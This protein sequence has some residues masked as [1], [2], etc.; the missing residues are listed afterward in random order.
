MTVSG[1]IYHKLIKENLLLKKEIERLQA[2]LSEKIN[3]KNENG[4]NYFNQKFYSILEHV[5]DV[6][7][8][9]SIK[10]KGYKYISPQVFQLLGYT[11]EEFIKSPSIVRRLIHPDSFRY[12]SEHWKKLHMG[13]VSDFYELKAIRKNKEIIWVQQRNLLI[14]DE[15]GTPSA[16]E[17]LV[18]DITEKKMAEGAL[19]KAKEKAEESDRLKSAFLA[20]TSHEILTPMNAIIGFAALLK[21][22]K[23]SEERKNSFIDIINSKSKQ[24]LQ[25]ISDII[26]I[27]KIEAGHIKIINKNFSLNVL[28][29]QL[30]LF[31]DT[32]KE[33]EKKLL[34][35]SVKNCL[36]DKESWI[37]SDKVRIEQI[38]TNFLSNAYK[39]TEKGRIEL[40]YTIEHNQSIVFYVRDTGI[41]INEHELKIIF[42]RFRQVS[43]SFSRIYGGVGLGLSIS[44]GI[45]EKLGGEIW[46][47][48]E[49][50]KG[51]TFYLRI[52]YKKGEEIK[53]TKRPKSEAYNWESKTILVA[54][55][56]D[57][58]YTLIE[59]LLKP[60][61]VNLLR[62][63]TG[64]EAIDMCLNKDVN[65]VLMDVKL[66]ELDG[67]EAS[68]RIKKYRDTLP[69]I[70]QT[71]YAMTSDEDSCL[72]AGC[73]AYISKPI[74]S[75]PL[76]KLIDQFI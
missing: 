26:D 1:R 58:N 35:I 44:K 47:E 36:S 14:T 63:I 28:T 34:R 46:V 72:K 2:T 49:I 59:T 3:C 19:V 16:I 52:P 61:K 54:E 41:G 33:R 69:I 68:R 37:Y 9:Y 62:A 64:L 42:D 17:G 4:N 22:K 6:V 65:L 57:V 7:Y 8:H 10:D 32:L 50:N 11:P 27:S 45:A 23:L 25:I 67:L 74:I 43:G 20:N 48:S 30:V 75:E 39:F 51:S 55:D 40:G 29:G 71:A 31:L 13:M 24:L 76:L 56:E 38:L 15:D 53:Q 66:P 73:D 60:T 12:F 5:N 21:S 18:T 70:A